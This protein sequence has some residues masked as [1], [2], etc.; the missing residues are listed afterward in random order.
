MASIPVPVIDSGAAYVNR[1][2]R[3]KPETAEEIKALALKHE[4]WDSSL[5]DW[6]LGKALADVNGGRLEIRRRPVTFVIDD[7]GG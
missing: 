7:T 4:L 5:V 2:Y 6:L 3:L 1:T